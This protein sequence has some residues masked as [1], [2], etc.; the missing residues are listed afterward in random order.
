M[1]RE[2]P[3]GLFGE[4]RQIG[5]LPAFGTARE[6]QD[7]VV[8]ADGICARL[9]LDGSREIAS[10]REGHGE[11]VE[12]LDDAG[13]L[14]SQRLLSNGQRPLIERLG[15]LVIMSVTVET[16]EAVERFGDAGM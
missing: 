4:G 10:R 16:G 11:A 3:I 14:R 6:I 1:Q 12:R 8:F 5:E 13:M 9:K 15:L 7:E 2:G